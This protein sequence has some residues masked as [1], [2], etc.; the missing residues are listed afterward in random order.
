MIMEKADPVEGQR[1]QQ[2]LKAEEPF[3]LSDI[4]IPLLVSPYYKS[5]SRGLPVLILS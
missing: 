2:M 3:S 4:I 5:R 1:Q